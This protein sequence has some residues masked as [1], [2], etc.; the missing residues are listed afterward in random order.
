MRDIA[1][2]KA[3]RS[4]LRQRKKVEMLL[5]RLSAALLSPARTR[6]R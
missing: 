2:T 6:L 4:S 3:C 5:A 1:W